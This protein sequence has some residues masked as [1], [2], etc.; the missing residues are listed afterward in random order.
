MLKKEICDTVFQT[1]S[2]RHTLRNMLR[3][4]EAGTRCSSDSFPRVASLCLRTI[5]DAGMKLC[6]RNT[7]H[8]IQ[9]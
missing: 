3:G 6:P 8:E 2:G 1:L 5:S 4:H 7:L 9:L